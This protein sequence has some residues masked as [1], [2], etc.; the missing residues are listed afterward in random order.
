MPISNKALKA[1]LWFFFVAAPV[2]FTGCEKAL[3][4]P[5]FPADSAR[6]LLYM[7]STSTSPPDV[8]FEISGISLRTG[9]GRW[10]GV[11]DEPVRIAAPSL[12]DRQILLKEAFVAPGT[13]TGVR[14]FISSAYVRGKDGLANL[15]LPQPDGKVFLEASFTLDPGQSFVLSFA[16]NPDASVVKRYLFEPAIDA[17]PQMPSAKG[18]LL[19]ISNSGSNYLS[20]IDRSLERVIGAVTVGN[21]PMGMALDTEQD[22]L[23]VVNSRSRSVSIVD[24]SQFLVLETIRLTAGIEPT[25]IVFMPD[26]T[27]P[28]EGK[29][30]IV[31]R[32]SNDVTVV[33]TVTKRL[34][35]S[36]A[37]GTH[38]SFIAADLDRREVYVT[39]ERSNNVSIINTAS[40]TV[41]ASITVDTR[42]TGIAVADDK[43]YVF[44]EGSHRVSVISA[45]SR[46]VIKTI[47]VVDAPRRGLKGFG[48]RLLIANTVDDTITFLNSQDV[49]TRTIQGGAGPV[50]LAGDELR[51]RAY[52]TNYNGS[53]VS[54]IDPIGERLLK[55]LFVGKSPY[56]AILIER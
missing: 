28:I 34:L 40:D 9:D 4:V 20:I 52:I 13:Y 42:P 19:F 26:V 43:I 49:V 11:V 47:S 17:I 45:S 22:R 30:Y 38:P 3:H 56:G 27:N 44:N 50:G 5:S 10:T 18:L 33:S 6:L 1:F 54:V 14:I 55:E 24:T 37:V 35:K 48:G 7:H 53:T 8:T 39:N 36:I 25:D 51:T 2:V 32:V 15:A 31:N 41:V 23:Y 21:R 29:L 16:W 46:K 12:V